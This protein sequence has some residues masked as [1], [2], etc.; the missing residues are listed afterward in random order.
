MDE[1]S[2]FMSLYDE[3]GSHMLSPPDSFDHIAARIDGL[4]V[5]E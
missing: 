2:S 3:D 4:P 5:L 1:F